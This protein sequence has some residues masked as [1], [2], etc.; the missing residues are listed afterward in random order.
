[1][2]RL[3]ALEAEDAQRVA[4]A[5]LAAIRPHA[6]PTVQSG[7]RE[8]SYQ[9]RKWSIELPIWFLD[10]EKG[11]LIAA[12]GAAFKQLRSLS[13]SEQLERGIVVRLRAHT[14]MNLPMF[15]PAA[16]VDTLRRMQAR[17]IGTR[18]L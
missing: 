9:G 8:V 1:M 11:K 14:L 2:L 6:G 16:I 12:V 10:L 5:V 15:V 17:A 18:H 13:R 7:N 3:A 4:D